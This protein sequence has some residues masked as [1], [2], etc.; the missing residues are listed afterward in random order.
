M[1]KNVGLSKTFMK[2]HVT[3]MNCAQLS[4]FVLLEA[5]WGLHD[6]SVI[7]YLSKVFYCQIICFQNFAMYFCNVLMHIS[8]QHEFPHP[9]KIY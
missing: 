3:E 4:I 2:I 8:H 1:K 9:F 7:S 5:K 6:A